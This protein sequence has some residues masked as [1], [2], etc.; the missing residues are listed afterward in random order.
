VCN[1]RCD[2]LLLSFSWLVPSFFVSHNSLG[3]FVGTT[4]IMQ[5]LVTS[6]TQKAVHE[7]R[8]FKCLSCYSLCI[9]PLSSEWLRPG[10][11]GLF[12]NLALKQYGTLEDKKLYTFTSFVSVP[13]LGCRPSILLSAVFWDFTVGCPKMSATNYHS[14]LHEI[15]KEPRSHLCHS[16]RMNLHICVVDMTYL[17]GAQVFEFCC[18]DILSRRRIIVCCV[19]TFTHW[20][21]VCCANLYILG[22]SLL[23]ANLY[24][25]SHLSSVIPPCCE[26]LL[27]WHFNISAA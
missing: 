21:I 16:R 7:R 9:A 11:N 8:V 4:N 10:N 17:N 12:Y 24:T 23:C 3:F 27:V 5:T 18:I 20:P 1:I 26:S 25:L 6:Q 2:T 13:L 19:L 22:Y 14:M 15:S